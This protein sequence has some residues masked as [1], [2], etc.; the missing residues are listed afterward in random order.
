MELRSLDSYPFNVK[1]TD[2]WSDEK[3]KD[4]YVVTNS[5]E[6]TYSL[7]PEDVKDY[8]E[9]DIKKSFVPEST[10]NKKRI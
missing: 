8:N 3:L 5:E 4:N 10:K 1:L 2:Y 6:K 9:T 7:K